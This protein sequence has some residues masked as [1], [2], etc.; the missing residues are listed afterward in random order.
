MKT[1]PS[2]NG[3]DEAAYYMI[4]NLVNILNHSF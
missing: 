1:A 4:D 3:G 2:G